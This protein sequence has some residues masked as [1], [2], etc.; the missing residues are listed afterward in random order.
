MLISLLLLSVGFSGITLGRNTDENPNQSNSFAESYF[1]VPTILDNLSYEING[2]T[3]HF[4][5][6]HVST[7]NGQQIVGND[8]I[9]VWKR[10]KRYV[11]WGEQLS[12]RDDA[13]NSQNISRS[14]YIDAM[15]QIGMFDYSGLLKWEYSLSSVTSAQV[16]ISDDVVYLIVNP[17]GNGLDINEET[18][19]LPSYEYNLL[20]EI[21][22]ESGKMNTH[23]Y[24]YNT[25]TYYSVNI[26][27]MNGNLLSSIRYDNLSELKNETNEYE[28]GRILCSVSLN[29][30]CERELFYA[31]GDFY[32]LS[33]KLIHGKP[34]IKIWYESFNLS[35]ANFSIDSEQYVTDSILIFQLSESGEVEWHHTFRRTVP[36]STGI[37]WGIS[38]YETNLGMLISVPIEGNRYY[39]DDLDIRF[40]Y[41][42]PRLLLYSLDENQTL[43]SSFNLEC[44]LGTGG[45]GKYMFSKNIFT[46][47]FSSSGICMTEGFVGGNTEVNA[48]GSSIIFI[49]IEN[50]KLLSSLRLAKNNSSI[51]HRFSVGTSVAM[52]TIISYSGG[53]NLNGLELI[54]N[55]NYT[56]GSTEGPWSSIYQL[57]FELD[58]DGDGVL[59]PVDECNQAEIYH[60]LGADGCISNS[61]PEVN[62]TLV[63]D[64]DGFADCILSVSDEDGDEVNASFFVIA[65]D[66][67]SRPRQVSQF[68]ETLDSNSS[69]FDCL[70]SSIIANNETVVLNVELSDGDDALAENV[71]RQF[72]LQFT[73]EEIVDISD[74]QNST[75]NDSSLPGNNSN[76]S[77]G[78]DTTN[79]S[80]QSLNQS[81]TTA[82]LTSD[83][84]NETYLQPSNSNE[85]GD[86]AND[87][88][89]SSDSPLIER[90][91]LILAVLV[92]MFV[93]LL[94]NSW[95][96]QT[97]PFK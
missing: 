51:F 43:M 18:I 10:T 47:R 40:P 52:V 44:P 87:L 12:Y 49:D 2:S 29:L 58:E 70:S 48:N 59:W 90:E 96:K 8:S 36:S 14:Q 46:L 63:W 25:L 93:G 64:E 5:T 15:M 42:S 66:Q 65:V 61:P 34:V 23:S 84:N 55:T 35:S 16:C 56:N 41:S 72:I 67:E 77:T 75:T 60:T 80:N 79:D 69:N 4:T 73:R 9:L 95:R 1:P 74:E 91:W 88:I 24:Y 32:I 7:Y 17:N 33:F 3:N 6:S 21:Q 54:E 62:V 50:G 28:R 81:N 57:M 22:L 68:D 89:S 76:S 39:F 45:I 97:P 83:S 27:C 82:N 20:I 30:I 92:F 78:N 38:V 85:T 53:I 19:M 13:A 86:D 71:S 11:P 37:G 26:K 31:Y 94:L